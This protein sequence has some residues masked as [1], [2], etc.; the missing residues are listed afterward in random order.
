LEAALVKKVSDIFQENKQLF[1]LTKPTSKKPAKAKAKVPGQP[2]DYHNEEVAAQISLFDAMTDFRAERRSG[3]SHEL[4]Q[5]AHALILC[6]LPYRS[7]DATEHVRLSR[8]ADGSL[9]RVTFY[10]LG[11]DKEG[12]RIPMAYG[13]DRTLLHWCVDRAIKLKSNFVPLANAVDFMRDVGQS[14]TGPNYARLRAAYQRISAMAIVVERFGSTEDRNITPIMKNSRL[15]ASIK[16]RE[17]EAEPIEGP[18]G[19]Q[20]DK[21]FFNEFM[22]NHVPF[23]WAM[24]RTLDQK[25]QMQ[26]YI[27]FLHWRSFAAKSTTLIPWNVM[28]EQLWQDDSNPWRIRSRFTEAIKILKVAWPELNAVA[29]SRGLRIGPPQKGAHLIPAHN[30]ETKFLNR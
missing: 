4:V 16:R 19:I 5:I 15:P 30:G 8:S 25:P 9:I 7:T 6:G 14:P 27:V 20:F 10:A 1:A 22:R 17:N 26:D 3:V 18:V 23:P 11:K 29:E 28:R 13:S 12:N 2:R 24:L 21:D